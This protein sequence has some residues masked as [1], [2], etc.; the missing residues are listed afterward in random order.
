[1]PPGLVRTLTDLSTAK[2]DAERAELRPLRRK[3]LVWWALRYPSVFLESRFTH[4][5]RSMRDLALGLAAAPLYP[6][7]K[8]ADRYLDARAAREWQTR[9][10]EQ[11]GSE[12]F[13]VFR[14]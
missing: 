7:S 12:M 10:H 3:V 8:L 13:L 1:M 6:L 11:N 2:G 9:R 5:R 4:R 14:R